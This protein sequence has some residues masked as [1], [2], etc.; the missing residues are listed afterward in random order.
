MTSPQTSWDAAVEAPEE[1]VVVVAAAVVEEEV[2]VTDWVG[3][4]SP[5]PSLCRPLLLLPSA[6]APLVVPLRI[7]WLRWWLRW[8]SQR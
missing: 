5:S 1:R 7:L 4:P 3:V 6:D 2:T 8:Y